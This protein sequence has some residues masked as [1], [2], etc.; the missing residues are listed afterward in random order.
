MERYVINE[1]DVVLKHRLGC[2][3][4]YILWGVVMLG[5][6]CALLFIDSDDKRVNYLYSAIIAVVSILVLWWLCRR[7]IKERIHNIPALV[8]TDHSIIVSRKNSEY[9]E[10]PFDVIQNFRLHRMRH[11]K[12]STT[13][14]QIYYKA[15]AEGEKFKRITDIDLDGLNMMNHKLEKLAKER[16]QLYNERNSLQ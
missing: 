13:Y 12:N 6:A 10:I 14:L 9:N 2:Q 16:L 1:G 8:I 3:V 11:E 15:P 5:L 7:V 4:V